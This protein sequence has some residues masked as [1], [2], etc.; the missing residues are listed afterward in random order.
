MLNCK[1]SVVHIQGGE[2]LIVVR[3]G[4]TEGHNHCNF[5]YYIDMHFLQQI[6]LFKKYYSKVMLK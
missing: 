1:T 5:L 4:M 2:L 3:V 6:M